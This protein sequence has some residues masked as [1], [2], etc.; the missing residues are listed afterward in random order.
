MTIA[1][2]ALPAWNLDTIFPGIDSPE[3]SEARSTIDR[4]LADAER[5]VDHLSA[6]ATSADVESWLVRFTELVEML[7]R[8]MT[9]LELRT[10]S[11]SRDED[12]QAALSS[13]LLLYA[14]AN[15]VNTRLTAWFGT[16]DLDTVLADSDVARDHEY[17][18]R[19]AQVIAQHQMSPAEEDLAS[20]LT[21]SGGTAWSK[22]HGDLWSQLA[23]EFET[24]PGKTETLTM[25]DLRNL[26]MHADRDVRRRAQDAELAT[27]KAWETAFAATLNGVKGEAVTLMARRKWNDPLDAAVFA[28]SIDRETLDAMMSA[29]RKAFPDL[30]RYLHLK[31]RALGI[32]KLAFYDLF[33]PVGSSER[34]WPWD[35]GVAFM[36]ENFGAYSDRL[37]DLAQRSLDEAWIDVPPRPGKGG[38]AF[39][40]GLGSG[41]SRV[42]LNYNPAYD[43]VST[44]AHELGHAYHNLC[45]AERPPLQAME[46]PNTLAETAS[47]FCETVLRKQAVAQA[48][49]DEALTILEGSLQDAVQIVIDITSRFL[50][51]QAVF[52]RR[53]DR[54]LSASEFNDLMLQ[55]QRDTYG[56]GLDEQTL[57]PYMWAVKTHYYSPERGYY[58]FPYMFGLLFALG[59]YAQFEKEPENFREQFDAL[60]ASTGE[61]DAATLAA[62]FGI[63]TRSEAFWTASLDVIRADIDEFERLVQDR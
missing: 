4:L 54:A 35:E 9:Y 13:A 17:L 34:V 30:R 20:D 7:V 27:W 28:N 12:A 8:Y 39:C 44:L 50:F 32:E 49:P 31:A 6:E 46:T 61:S 21:L 58:N 33:A 40:A 42:L 62:S 52:A 41:V 18:L 15:K 1:P 37:R 36:L 63:D 5:D 56:D 43:G 47:T 19:K 48:E 53:K 24:E 29:A 60:L 25:S 16:I 23:I 45:L 26:A 2:A 10:E 55:A 22:L 51:E 57:H 3:F 14:R 59:L 38:G 11:N